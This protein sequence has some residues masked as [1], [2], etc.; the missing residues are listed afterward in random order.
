MQ[1]ISKIHKILFPPFCSYCRDFLSDNNMLC[2]GCFDEIKP[3]ATC[4]LKITKDH[5]VKVFSIGSYKD[6]LK[7]LIR[8]KHYRQRKTFQELGQLLWDRTNL[9]HHSFDVIVPIPLH[10]TRYAWRWFNQS[11]E[12]AQAI[13]KQSGKPVMS[14]LKRVKRTLFQTGLARDKR[15]QNVKNVFE[16][17]QSSAQIKNKH[18]VLIDDVMTTGTTLKEA[19]K[20]LK[21]ARPASITIA[22]IARVL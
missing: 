17:S 15:I 1:V 22:V 9:Q 20:E 21:K 13:S 14:I 3:I 7:A 12:I 19:I 6:P 10:W 11:E 18:I 4:P 8:A 5:E 16:L 2:N